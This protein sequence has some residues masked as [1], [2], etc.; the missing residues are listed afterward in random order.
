MSPN[1]AALPPGGDPAAA[2]MLSACG[3]GATPFGPNDSAPT[4]VARGRRDEALAADLST[5]FD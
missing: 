1:P 5:A 3:A 2:V 4:A